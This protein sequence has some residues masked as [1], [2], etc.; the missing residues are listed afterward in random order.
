MV[1]RLPDLA[2]LYR[3]FQAEGNRYEQVKREIVEDE[4]PPMITIPAYREKYGP[5][6]EDA[7]H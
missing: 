2:T 6:E 4:R 1:D 7:A 3:Q 5:N